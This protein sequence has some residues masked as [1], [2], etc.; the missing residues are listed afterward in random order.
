MKFC[1]FL[2]RKAALWLCL[3]CGAHAPKLISAPL[4]SNFMLEPSFSFWYSFEHPK[5]AR[6]IICYKGYNPWNFW[7]RILIECWWNWHL[8]LTR[9]AVGV[10]GR[11]TR[12][13]CRRWRRSSRGQRAGSSPGRCRPPRTGSHSGIGESCSSCLRQCLPTVRFRLF[14]NWR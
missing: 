14:F 8:A 3:E 2:P 1:E 5:M 10:P 7:K 13:C 4:S 6:L 9:E 11:R 12:W